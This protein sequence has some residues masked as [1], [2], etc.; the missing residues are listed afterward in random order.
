MNEDCKHCG[1]PIVSDDGSYWCHSTFGGYAGKQRCDPA[2]SGL[3]YGYNAE[4]GNAACTRICLG[5]Q[6]VTIG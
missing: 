2:H 6:N 1:K 3:P 4:P 5:Y